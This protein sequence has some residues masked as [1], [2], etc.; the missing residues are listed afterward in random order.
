MARGKIYSIKEGQRILHTTQN[1]IVVPTQTL[2]KD[3]RVDLRVLTCVSAISNVDNFLQSGN[4]VRYCSIKKLNN[5]LDTIGNLLTM[6]KG[7]LMKKVREIA[8]INSEEFCTRKRMCEQEM[9]SCI[10]INYKSGGFITIEYEIME[11]LVS[12]LGNNAFKLYINLL[13][14]CKD[15]TTNRYVERQL[16]QEFLLGLIGLSKNSKRLLK[17]AEDE[18]IENNLIQI[19]TKWETELNDDL[20]TSTPITKKYY[21]IVNA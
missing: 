11:R 2:I 9:T 5:N 7:K 4:N 16:T 14:L 12:T 19:K 8:G 6:D 13:W 20:T 21:K 18:L 10:E 3:K 1:S 15:N 17:K